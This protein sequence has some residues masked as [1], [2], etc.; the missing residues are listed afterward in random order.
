MIDDSSGVDPT[1]APKPDTCLNVENWRMSKNRL[2]E[3]L[4]GIADNLWWCWQPEVWQLFREIDRDLWRETNHNP[5]EFLE[6][7]SDDVLL[8]RARERA[9]AS[10]IQNAHRRMTEYVAETGPSANTG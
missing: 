4:E 9:L 8:A 7:I 6:S 2:V 1:A 5:V 10:R 3:Q